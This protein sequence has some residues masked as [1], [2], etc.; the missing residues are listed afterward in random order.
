MEQP[1]PTH[2]YLEVENIYTLKNKLQ[3]EIVAYLQ[4]LHQR[5][6]IAKGVENI[7][8]VIIQVAA[9]KSEDNKR[10][11]PIVLRFWEPEPNTFKL[12]GL[13]QVSFSI[14]PSYYETK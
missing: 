11:K 4:T 5:L 12:E 3:K 2:Y 9:K 8:D 10:C 6:V 1:T 14:K 7:K 13:E